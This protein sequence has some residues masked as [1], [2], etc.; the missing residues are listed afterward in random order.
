MLGQQIG[1]IGLG[2]MGGAMARN[3]LSANGSLMVFDNNPEA[4]Q[5]L[6]DAGASVCRRAADM[7]GEC[8]IIVLCLPFTTQVRETLFGADGVFGDGV[9]G[10][11]ERGE[12]DDPLTILD[13]TT[14][15]REDA[16]Q[17]GAEVSATG[18]HYFDCPVSGLPKRAVDGSL[19]IMFGGSKQGFNL[20]EPV[21]QTMGSSVLHCGELG[22]GQAMKAVNNIIYNINISA[23]CEILP[24]AVA[25]GLDSEELARLVTSGSSRSFAAEHFVPKMLAREFSGDFAMQDAHKDIVNMQRIAA[26]AGADTPVM[27]AMISS[28]QQTMDSGCGGEPKHAMIK[29][30]EDAL[31]VTFRS[32]TAGRAIDQAVDSE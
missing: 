21:L 14:L 11:R 3:L 17:I 25:A 23:I 8:K 19:T 2:Q 1:F 27:N 18:S 4:T 31:G 5:V 22:C 32:H 16:L 7:R 12:A 26:A 29:R 10:D 30:Y 6:A 13:A 24:L 15:D 28:Y 20:A 9:F